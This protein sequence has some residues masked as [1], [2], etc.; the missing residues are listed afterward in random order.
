MQCAQDVVI[1]VG[2]AD[3][4]VIVRSALRQFLDGIPDMQVVGEAADGAEAIRLVQCKQMDV[5]ILDIKMPRMTGIEAL[6]AIRAT[7]PDVRVVV[8]SAYLPCKYAQQAQEAGA[9]AYL[10]KACDVHRV[11]DVIRAAAR[12]SPTAANDP[13]SGL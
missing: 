11:T 1:R 8:L 5:L 12:M 13:A 9:V 4:H 3:D 6:A 7:A 2:I 10:E